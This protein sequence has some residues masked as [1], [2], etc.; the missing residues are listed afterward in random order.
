MVHG[1]CQTVKENPPGN[2]KRIPP[3][4]KLGKIIDSNMPDGWGDVSF[5]ESSAMKLEWEKLIFQI[6]SDRPGEVPA[7]QLPCDFEDSKGVLNNRSSYQQRNIHRIPGLQIAS[8]ILS[9]DS[10]EVFSFGDFLFLLAWWGFSWKNGEPRFYF[11]FKDETL[12]VFPQSSDTQLENPP[13]FNRKFST[14]PKLNKHGH[15]KVGKW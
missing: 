10:Q 15:M 14:P 4:G 1:N 8:P 2:G 7:S 12:Q 13:R 3:N 9:H 5:V 11:S 6:A